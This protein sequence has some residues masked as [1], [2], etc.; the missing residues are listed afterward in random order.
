[1]ADMAGF[2]IQVS[3]SW[4]PTVKI[5]FAQSSYSWNWPTCHLPYS[6]DFLFQ[7]HDWNFECLLHWAVLR[8]G[9]KLAKGF[10]VVAE[11]SVAI[12]IQCQISLE[13]SFDLNFE[14][15]AVETRWKLRERYHFK[16]EY[17]QFY[18]PNFGDYEESIF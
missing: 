11:Q 14:T 18:K 6:S 10:F 9:E 12:W 8:L 3:Y 2:K 1:M 13:N 16:V 4:K 15:K 5:T 7:W 17:S